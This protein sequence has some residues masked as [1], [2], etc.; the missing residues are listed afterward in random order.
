MENIENRKLENG[1][2]WKW[3][4]LGRERERVT[5]PVYLRLPL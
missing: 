4:D 1:K 5:C 3:L 2:K